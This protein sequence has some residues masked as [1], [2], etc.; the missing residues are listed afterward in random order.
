MK[1][2]QLIQLN[3]A[4]FDLK[5]D[6]QRI[7]ALDRVDTGKH[8]LIFIPNGLIIKIFVAYQGGRKRDLIGYSSL[9]IIGIT[10]IICV[11]QLRFVDH[12]VNRVGAIKENCIVL[13]ADQSG[14]RLT[15]VVWRTIE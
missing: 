3:A 11:Y 15:G 5:G 9:N 12:N 6:G 8:K 13:P 7:A 14:S 10:P 2:M 4:V 1:V